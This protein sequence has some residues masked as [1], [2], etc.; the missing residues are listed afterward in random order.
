MEGL[1]KYWKGKMNIKKVANFAK[2]I[3]L[4]T[5]NCIRFCADPN[6]TWDKKI[7]HT[8]IYK[9]YCFS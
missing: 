7:I 5:F 9:F 1:E 4:D 2:D 6:N 8:S 3:G